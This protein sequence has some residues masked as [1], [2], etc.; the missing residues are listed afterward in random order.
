MSGW[1]SGAWTSSQWQYTGSR[2]VGGTS[3]AAWAA[4]SATP[5]M[6][7]VGPTPRGRSRRTSRTRR[8]R[9]TDSWTIYAAYDS[10]LGSNEKDEDDVVKSAKKQ[11]NSKR[12][13]SLAAQFKNYRRTSLREL[14]DYRRRCFYFHSFKNTARIVRWERERWEAAGGDVWTEMYDADFF[15]RG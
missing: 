2:Q 4:A 5:A 3:S 11:K 1:I 7:M 15:R 12:H 8:A 6:M 14:A 10:K 13:K 9:T